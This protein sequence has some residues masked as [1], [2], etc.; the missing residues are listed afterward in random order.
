MGASDQSVLVLF[1]S[2][3]CDETDWDCGGLELSIVDGLPAQA[4]AFS[5][6]SAAAHMRLVLGGFLV[7]GMGLIGVFVAHGI[8]SSIFAKR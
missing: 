1:G 3:L 7:V 6:A 4:L 5:V 2:Q 8:L